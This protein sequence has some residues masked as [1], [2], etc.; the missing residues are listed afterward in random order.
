MKSPITLTQ[1]F[2]FENDQYEGGELHWIGEMGF[3]QYTIYRPV[4]DDKTDNTWYVYTEHMSKSWLPDLLEQ[5]VEQM[6][7]TG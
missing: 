3:G 5:W 4:K 6:E 2:P 7:V 1:A